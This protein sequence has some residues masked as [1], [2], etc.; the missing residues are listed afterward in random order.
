MCA[1]KN[2]H[3]S[4]DSTSRFSTLFSFSWASIFREIPCT[5]SNLLEIFFIIRILNAKNLESLLDL[6]LKSF[7]KTKNERIFQISRLRNAWILQEAFVCFCQ[8]SG[9]FTIFKRHKFG[10]LVP[11]FVLKNLKSLEM[12]KNSCIALFK[13]NLAET[14]ECPKSRCLMLQFQSSISPRVRTECP[15]TTSATRRRFS[16]RARLEMGLRTGNPKSSRTGM[17]CLVSW[18]VLNFVKS[19]SLFFFWRKD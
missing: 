6:K 11:T 17:L 8:F 13:F 19:T 14:R 7:G 3:T 1:A 15:R 16:S 9:K 10:K 4:P 18:K 2:G 5:F 12:K